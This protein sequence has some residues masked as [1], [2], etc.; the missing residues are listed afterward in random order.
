MGGEQGIRGHN[1][2]IKTGK[3]T[4]RIHILKIL[5]QPGFPFLCQIVAFKPGINPGY[6]QLISLIPGFRVSLGLQT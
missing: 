5:T 4:A 1:S 3:K 6:S 2:R